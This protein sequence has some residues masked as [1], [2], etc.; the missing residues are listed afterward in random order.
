V[1]LLVL[2]NETAQPENV[3]ILAGM[4]ANGLVEIV[5]RLVELAAIPQDLSAP[6]VRLPVMAG[7]GNRLRE[8]VKRQIGLAFGRIGD[9]TLLIVV[10][11]AAASLDQLGEAADRRVVSAR[12][13]ARPHFLSHG[14]L[15]FLVR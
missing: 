2:V 8:I 15:L 11:I 10:E 3:R 4:V 6:E 7:Q 12:I 13:E 14:P 1:G 5:E 9:A